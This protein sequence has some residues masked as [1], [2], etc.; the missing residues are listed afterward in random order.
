MELI[1]SDKLA[2]INALYDANKAESKVGVNPLSSPLLVLPGN[3]LVSMDG[4][5]L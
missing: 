5:I 2:Q 3:T 1:D 4:E